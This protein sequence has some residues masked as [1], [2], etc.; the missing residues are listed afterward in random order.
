M[1]Q[2]NT[3]AIDALNSVIDGFM[4]PIFREED[5]STGRL[6][7]GLGPEDYRRVVDGYGCADC[8]AKFRVYTAACPL[9]GWTR[10]IQ[11]DVESAPGYWLQ[12]L[13]DRANPDWGVTY[14]T[15]QAK[16]EQ[17]LADIHADRDVEHTTL[18]KLKPR[19]RK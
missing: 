16:I 19:R 6:L 18:K 5:P 13:E 17:A 7:N 12:H 8:L 2:V 3:A 4:V 11:N 9:C 14:P 1:T 10:N 15:T